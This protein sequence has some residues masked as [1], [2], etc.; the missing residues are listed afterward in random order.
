MFRSAK[1]EER[2]EIEECDEEEEEEEEE[3]EKKK[4]SAKRGKKSEKKKKEQQG[5]QAHLG[6]LGGAPLRVQLDDQPANGAPLLAGEEEKSDTGPHEA[7]G[8]GQDR[9]QD[10]QKDKEH[11]QHG[12]AVDNGG[13][14]LPKHGE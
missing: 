6:G 12:H 3:C 4:M 11:P 5:T 14:D 2:K 7:H 9:P 1:R 10:L 8:G 13:A